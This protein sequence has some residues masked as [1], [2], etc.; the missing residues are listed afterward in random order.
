[1]LSLA[2]WFGT[3]KTEAKFKVKSL[4]KRLLGPWLVWLSGL[5]GDLQSGR[6]LVQIPVRAHARVVDQ[7]PGCVCA[8]GNR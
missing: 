4:V 8:R 2:P 1:M 6:L 5:S 7:V 3:N